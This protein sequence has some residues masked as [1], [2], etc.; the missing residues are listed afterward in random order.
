MD[1][2]LS[3]LSDVNFFGATVVFFILMTLISL[4]FFV[5]IKY[6]FDKFNYKKDK[7]GNWLLKGYLCFYLSLV[8][9]GLITIFANFL[10]N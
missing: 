4:I 6:H 1:D 8:L 10:I 5:I 3:N 7:K 9:I 2:I